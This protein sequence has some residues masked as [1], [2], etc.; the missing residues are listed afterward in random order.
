[1]IQFAQGIGFWYQVISG[2][3]LF[4]ICGIQLWSCLARF[5][6]RHVAEELHK[7]YSV[8]RTKPSF[9]QAFVWLSASDLDFWE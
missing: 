4:C 8:F 9:L 2:A 3:W 6:A 7:L 5:I 1:M